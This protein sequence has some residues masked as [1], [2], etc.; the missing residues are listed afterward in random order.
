[1]PV[2]DAALSIQAGTTMTTP[3]ETSTCTTSPVARCSLY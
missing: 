1:M 3:G 2:Q